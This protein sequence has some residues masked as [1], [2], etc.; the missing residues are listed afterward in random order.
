MSRPQ[1]PKG[2]N[3]WVATSVGSELGSGILAFA[4]TWV[5][6]GYGPQVASWVLTLTVAPS[7]VLGLL[8]GAVADRF[9]ARR[10]MI[11]GTL[12]LMILSGSLAAAVSI[13][14]TPPVMLMLTAALIGTVAAFHRPAVGVFPRLFV[15]ESSMLGAAM[16]RAGMASQLARIIAPP[17]G[18]L[19]VG[20]IA[21]SGVALIDVLGCVAMLVTLLLIHPPLKQSPVAEAVTFRGIVSGI[22]TARTTRGVP[23]L[24]LC[25]AI[26][27]GAVIP[28]VLLGIPLAA[29][30][31]GWTAAEAGLIEAG[32]IAGG[33]LSGAWFAWRGTASKAWRPMAAGPLIVAAGLGL[34]AISPTS[35]FAVASTTLI[36]IGVVV[37]TAH[38]FP[39]YILLAPPTM[40]SRF[41]SLLILV[42]QA[43]QLIVN[44]LIGLAVAAVGAGP[45]IAASGVIALL[46]SL[47][48]V[49]DRTLR[50]ST[51]DT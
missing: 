34:L 3:A 33:L 51:V 24:L 44:P 48:V 46:A 17:L 12:A 22:T 25:V 6:S 40:L 41:Q 32:W 42:Q 23:A 16:A 49:T 50:T 30:E 13:W 7:V 47:V 38:V 11:F 15:E 18:G 29:R 26:V 37:F 4:L 9:G 36:G 31:R 10:V 21:L 14:G 45:M 20:M 35:P 8:G 28:A 27:A 39:T 1:L 43:P 2:F 5:A 19:L